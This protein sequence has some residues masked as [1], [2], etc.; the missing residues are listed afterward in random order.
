MERQ[1]RRQA[2]L[3]QPDI[4]GGSDD[5]DGHNPEEE[6]DDDYGYEDEVEDARQVY[7]SPSNRSRP[8]SSSSRRTR[9]RQNG[10]VYDFQAPGPLVFDEVEEAA[11]QRQRR[12]RVE[13]H[14]SPSAARFTPSPGARH[15]R[16]VDGFSPASS[17]APMA[18]S[19]RSPASATNDATVRYLKSRLGVLEAA[20]T[21][22]Q[23]ETGSLRE[24]LSSAE[25]EKASAE[26]SAN[27]FRTRMQRAET[28]V[29][30]LKRSNESLQSKLADRDAEAASLRADIRRIEQ[31]NKSI[32][33]ERRNRDVRLNRALQSVQ[34]YKEKLRAQ[35]NN[36]ERSGDVSR[37]ELAQLRAENKRLKQQKTELMAAFNKQFKLIDLLKRQK[38]H[39][40]AAKLLQFT[41]EEFLR[42]LELGDRF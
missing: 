30:K 35:Q 26:T 28:R 20:V 17:A 2:Q 1:H 41:E 6:E 5:D 40:E 8:S 10:G 24:Q 12:G 23:E 38:M 42:S 31:E 27:E 9:G 37:T 21:K 25:Q 15:S 7:A 18:A 36:A 16:A 3:A 39:M 4:E 29:E 19:N 13:R 34:K 11:P 32:V 22:L 14:R 33:A